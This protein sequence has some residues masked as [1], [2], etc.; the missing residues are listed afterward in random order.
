[1]LW[2]RQQI[3]YLNCD[4]S[5]VCKYIQNEQNK[6]RGWICLKRRGQRKKLEEKI[7]TVEPVPSTYMLK[8]FC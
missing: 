8:E 7:I 4:A 2:F 1:M 6:W 5:P 3:K